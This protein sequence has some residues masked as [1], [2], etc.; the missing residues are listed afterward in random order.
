[1]KKI[2]KQKIKLIKYFNKILEFEREYEEL[3]ISLV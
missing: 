3:I 2:I 1:M